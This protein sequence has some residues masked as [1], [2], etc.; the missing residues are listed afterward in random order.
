MVEVID[1]GDAQRRTTGAEGGG[2][3]D[4]RVPQLHFVAL[5]VGHA[6]EVEQASQVLAL[7]CSDRR[8]VE[9]HHQVG[10]ALVVADRARL[11]ERWNVLMRSGSGELRRGEAGAQQITVLVADRHVDEERLVADSSDVA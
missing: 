3:D 5:T 1:H 4:P 11:R 7:L 10:D 9:Q 6:S 8:A 2:A